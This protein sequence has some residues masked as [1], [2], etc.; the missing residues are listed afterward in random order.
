MGKSDQCNKPSIP[1]YQFSQ[2]NTIYDHFEGEMIIIYFATGKYLRLNKEATRLID[3][4]VKHPLD[5][6]ILYNFIATHPQKS[7]KL[8]ILIHT[9]LTE[10][11]LE[12][13]HTNIQNIAQMEGLNLFLLSDAIEI[14]EA[15]VY[16]DMKYLLKLDDIYHIDHK[17]WPLK[18]E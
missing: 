11:I 4:L 15:N 14:V 12:I 17:N 2:T 1:V 9:L 10:K 8:K 6:N 3:F 13:H 16:D 18:D 5:I 7:E